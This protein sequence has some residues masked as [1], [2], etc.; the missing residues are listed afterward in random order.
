MTTAVDIFSEFAISETKS[1][2]GVWVPFKDGVEFLIAK[3]GNKK[4]RRLAASMMNK[5][6]RILDQKDGDGVST[7][8]AEAKL[9][10]IMVEIMAKS[11]LLGWRGN[12]QFQGKPLEY[13]EDNAR[14]LLK[15]EGFRSLV[16]DLAAD[17]A[18]F[19]EV[20]EAEE[21]KN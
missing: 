2:E 14:K 4:F 19:K 9:N 11:V 18:Y 15:L 6:K 1:Q 17:E 10:E 13:T 20:Q 7:E 8:A 12:L 16:S 21:A 5:N 3:S